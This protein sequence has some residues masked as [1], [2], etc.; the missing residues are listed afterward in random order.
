M[1][2]NAFQWSPDGKRLVVREPHRA[3]RLR[4]AAGPQERRAP[5]LAHFVQVQRHGMV[6]R[7][8]GASVDGGLVRRGAK[9]ITYG[10]DWNDTDP[11]WSP[12][13]TRIAFV[14]DRTGKEYRRRPQHATCG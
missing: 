14:S 6:R 8:A 1:A 11:Q 5:L 10:D 7:Q 2:R 12:D 3:E 4:G 9:Q 13:G